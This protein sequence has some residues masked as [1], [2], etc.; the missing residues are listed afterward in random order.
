MNP[1]PDAAWWP[2]DLEKKHVI[3]LPN[4]EVTIYGPVYENEDYTVFEASP[5]FGGR[6]HFVGSL[7]E[8]RCLLLELST[9]SKPRKP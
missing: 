5:G 8:L 3:A 7:L 4:F 6:R 2:L 1:A 9:R